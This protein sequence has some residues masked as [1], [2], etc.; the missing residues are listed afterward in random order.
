V[1]ALLLKRCF[2]SGG[3][4]IVWRSLG[5]KRAMIRLSQ[6][7]LIS[8]EVMVFPRQAVGHEIAAP[9]ML[10]DCAKR[11]GASDV[12]HGSE[13]GGDR[14]PSRKSFRSRGRAHFR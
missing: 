1:I 12:R 7:E 4:P 14:K 9:D 10:G 5:S 2:R 13:S 6:P 11:Y 8:C 3:G